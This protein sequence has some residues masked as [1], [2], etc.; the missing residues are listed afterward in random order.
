MTTEPPNILDP[1]WSEYAIENLEAVRSY[2]VSATEALL[3]GDA[4]S[5]AIHFECVR[6]CG[7]E[8]AVAIKNMG[9]AR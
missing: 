6:L 8:V 1:L 2:A 4:R 9:G 7:R 5:S 3:R